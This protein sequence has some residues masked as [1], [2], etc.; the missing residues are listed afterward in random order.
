MKMLTPPNPD[1][2]TNLFSIN[3]CVVWLDLIL[4]LI[5]LIKKERYTILNIHQ[6]PDTT[7]QWICI[8]IDFFL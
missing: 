6:L 4:I 1:T 3:S 5:L 7:S 2:R 8:N